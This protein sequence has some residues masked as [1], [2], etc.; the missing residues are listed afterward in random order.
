MARP[1]GTNP[2]ERWENWVFW[3]LLGAH[4]LPLWSHR[5]FLTVDGPAHLY[6]AWLLKAML[7][8]PSNTAHQL[9]AFNFN[10]EPNYLSHVLPGGLLTLLLP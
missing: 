4:L 10:P 5:Y 9:L 8:H 7:M 1:A 3:L 2:P 6:N